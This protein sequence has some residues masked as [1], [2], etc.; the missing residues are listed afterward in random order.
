MPSTAAV[1][2]DGVVGADEGVDILDA[3]VAVRHELVDDLLDRA[4]HRLT[5]VG[6][7]EAA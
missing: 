5:T 6:V 3:G 2:A 7:V 1:D 4:G